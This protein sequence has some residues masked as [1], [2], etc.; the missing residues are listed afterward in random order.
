LNCFFAVELNCFSLFTFGDFGNSGD[1]ICDPLPASLSQQPHPPIALLLKAKAKPQ[2]DRAVEAFFRVFSGLNRVQS[3]LALDFL[4]SSNPNGI[5]K[6]FKS[7]FSP[8]ETIGR[9]SQPQ[10]HKT[11]RNPVAQNPVSQI[12]ST[13]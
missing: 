11:Q 5:N 6:S 1:R 2:F 9:G 10:T 8:A 3:N 4:I 12:P 13:K 7:R